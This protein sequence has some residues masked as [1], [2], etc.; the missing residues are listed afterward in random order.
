MAGLGGAVGAGDGVGEVLDSRGVEEAEAFAEDVEG[1][2]G[3]LVFGDGA[4]DDDVAG[5]VAFDLRLEER[6]DG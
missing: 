4:A 2:L 1:G 6:A 5:V 3:G